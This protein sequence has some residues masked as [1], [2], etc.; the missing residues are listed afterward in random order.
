MAGYVD[1]YQRTIDSADHGVKLVLGPTGLGK[2]TSI[3]E[4]IRQNP[5]RKFVYMANRKQLLEAMAALITPGECVVLRRDLE[6]VQ[7][8]LLTQRDA[9]EALL[10]EPR[11]SEA[12]KRANQIVRL[13][14]LDVVS[15]RRACTQVIEMTGQPRILPEWL[16]ERVDEQ[17][18]IVLQAV[19]WALFVMRD[20]TEQNA[21]Y[22]WMASH[23][24]VEALFP[25]IAFRYR[26]EVRLLLLTLQKA[27]YGFF[28]GKGT[29]SL[30]N[31]SD[32]KGLVIFLDEFDFLEH[33]LVKMICRAPQIDDPFDFV[34]HFS[35]AMTQ[36]K[37]PKVDYPYSTPIR[38][39]IERII[40]II[41]GVQQRGIEYPRYNQFTWQKETTK[42]KERK[43]TP[44]IFRTRHAISTTPLFI[45]QTERSFQLETQRTD[46]RWVTASWFFNAVGTAATR[47]LTLFKELQR[48]DEV[49]YREMMH[50]SFRNT[51]FLE[52]VERIAQFPSHHQG[53]MTQRGT[54]L[55]G[56]YSL[57]DI[58]D[59][60]QRTDNEEV[61]V[62]HYQMLQTP[63][64]LLRALAESYL[65]FGLS[66]TADLPRS[67]HH[68]DLAW[69]DGEGLLL[70]TT[71]EDR[72]D[73]ERLSAKKAALR[74]NQIIVAQIN[75]LDIADPFQERLHVFLEAV[76]HDDEFVEDK[77]GHRSNRMH[78]FWAALLWLL[79]QGGEQQRML[80][81]LNSFHQVRQ[82]FTTFARHAAE[83]DIYTVKPLQDTQW[84][85]AVTIMVGERQIRI[86]FFDAALATQTHQNKDVDHAFN[87]LFWCDDPVVVVTQYLSAG[88][89]VN[90]QYT[91]E[92]GGAKRDF[93][94]IALLES[95]YFFFIKP[96]EEMSPIEILAAH[97]A[98]I[99]Y[100]AKLFAAKQISEDRF[101]QVL[102]TINRPSE[103]NLRYRQ[104]STATDW[105][106]NQIAIF[107]QA[108]GRIE[109]AWSPT[110]DQVVLMAPEV[111]SA[112]QAFMGP[113]FEPIREQRAPFGS[114]NL[115]AV[116]E[117]ISHQTAQFEREAR[118]R[119]DTRLRERNDQSKIAIC[120]LVK[121]LEQ[122]RQHGN[123]DIRHD[124]EDLRRA[125]LQ[126]D[127]QSEVV[128]R[129]HCMMT[130]PYLNRGRLNL[131]DQIE[132]LPLDIAVPGSRIVHLDAVYAVISENAIIR[133]HFVERG[134][135]LRFDHPGQQFFTPYCLQAILAGAIGEEAV[136][137]LLA[138]EGINVEG[139]PDA[140]FEI[141]DLAIV[142]QPWYIDCK[143]YNELTLDRFAVAIDDPLWHPTLNERYFVGH[144][145]AKLERINRHSGLASKI[146]YINLVSGQERPLGYYNSN[147]ELVA[148]FAHAQIIVVQGALDREAPNRLHVAFQTFLDD[149]GHALADHPATD[150]ED[151]P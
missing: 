87:S 51:D 18:R 65:V 145:R 1:Y 113:D 95:P 103:W 8:V 39:R 79:A 63:E 12:L 16:A 150:P 94:H 52:Q 53:Q 110:P 37:L 112:F 126:H 32:E 17:A 92:E 90:L 2:T 55:D 88:N 102:G 114:A 147:F 35:Q 56:G 60:Q 107:I 48:D 148:D 19:R 54:L 21:A 131:T 135:D 66:A 73:I 97:K 117:Q 139:L 78:R 5:E 14:T 33:D 29:R 13:K 101:R 146:M 96:D 80:L 59:L 58:D 64:G 89:G 7:Q 28:D 61:E 24:V 136:T 84:F 74:G 118:R 76:A 62:H 143:N 23:P 42:E 129:Y 141:A 121:Q 68:F 144:A 70:P 151:H 115:H 93:T 125:V 34:R 99:W 46:P 140:L 124:W 25:A 67:V 120:S 132:I 43:T 111:F 119:R 49:R 50:Q 45:H 15:I 91:N 77:G 137:A 47:I 3:I 31:L 98:N 81:F 6:V 71:P 128:A 122:V 57:F 149:L 86:V 133:E 22:R 75:V 109:R 40:E 130:S 69:L 142:G 4:V 138:H 41:N 27:Y 100:Q 85:D 123:M 11:F 36:H 20:T 10:T 30:T 83:A 38:H 106:F 104:G 44:A 72:A 9:F 82:L 116:L 105:L 127:F 134:Y 108:L 26:T